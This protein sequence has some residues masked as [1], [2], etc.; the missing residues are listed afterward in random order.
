MPKAIVLIGVTGT[1][2]GARDTLSKRTGTIGSS[3]EC[4]LVLHDRDVL[5]RHAEIRQVLD[6]WFIVPLTPGARIFVNGAPVTSQGRLLEGDLV[7]IGTATFKTGF[8]ETVARA[9]G[10][11]PSGHSTGVPRIGEYLMK[12]GLVSRIQLDYAIQRQEELRRRGRS[13]QL[14]D[15]LYELGYISRLDLNRVL[16]EQSGDYQNHFYD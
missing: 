5:P 6:R 9:V 14:G 2:V 13:M 11:N 12:R 7:T 15:V 8:T 10:A 1:R 16:Q 4:D 3:S